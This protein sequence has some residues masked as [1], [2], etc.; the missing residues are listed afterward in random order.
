MSKAPF[1]KPGWKLIK[2]GISSLEPC[3]NPLQNSNNESEYINIHEIESN[4]FVYG[5]THTKRLYSESMG[6]INQY[7]FVEMDH[8][9]NYHGIIS[10]VGFMRV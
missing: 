5:T 2:L 1:S 7:L 10:K 4:W 6:E 3:I 9:H 8:N